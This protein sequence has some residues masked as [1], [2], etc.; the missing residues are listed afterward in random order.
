MNGLARGGNGPESV[1]EHVSPNP[2]PPPAGRGTAQCH[3]LAARCAQQPPGVSARL[4]AGRRPTVSAARFSSQL[5]AG[6]GAGQHNRCPRLGQRDRVFGDTAPGGQRGQ[7]RRW[8]A[9]RSQPPIGDRLPDQDRPPRRGGFGRGRA[10]RWLQEV[11]PERR[12][13]Q[14]RGYVWGAPNKPFCRHHWHNVRRQ[15]ARNQADRARMARSAC[16]EV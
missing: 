5:R 14:T 15:P 16:Y 7:R 1:P 13:D 12:P 10:C 11:P 2:A 9:R 4:S 6:D 8:P 3:G